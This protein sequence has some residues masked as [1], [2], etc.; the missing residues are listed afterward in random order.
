ML[1]SVSHNH[2][3][4]F[5]RRMQRWLARILFDK[6]KMFISLWITNECLLFLVF[7]WQQAAQQQIRR[8]YLGAAADADNIIHVDE[9]T[10]DRDIIHVD[11]ST[12]DPDIIHADESLIDA[13]II[14]ADESP[15]DVAI[16]EKN[17]HLVHLAAP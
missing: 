15:T 17:E 1:A 9:S 14:H 3:N 11:E 2:F 4:K 6:W 12:T 5:K 16:L 13:D 8:L 7:P 10:I